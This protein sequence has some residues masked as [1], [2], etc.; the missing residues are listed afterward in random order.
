MYMREWN[1]N[2]MIALSC[3]L[4]LSPKIT[5]FEVYDTEEHGFGI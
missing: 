4:Y 1:Q 2:F 3:V 5:G